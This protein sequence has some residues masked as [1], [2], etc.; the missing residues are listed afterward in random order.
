MKA[1]AKADADSGSYERAIQGARARRR[2]ERARCWPSSRNWNW[3]ICTGRPARRRKPSRPSSAS[4]RYNP[5]SPALDYALY[6]RALINFQRQPGPDG[7]ARRPG[8]RR[9][10]PARDARRTR[11]P[12]RSGGSC[13]APDAARSAYGLHRQHA[14]GPTRCTSR[15]TTSIGRCLRGGRQPRAAGGDRVPAG[16]G[17]GGS[18]CTSWCAATTSCSCCRCAIRLRALK[19]NFPDSPYVTGSVT[20]T[21]NRGGALLGAPASMHRH[22]RPASLAPALRRPAPHRRQRRQWWR[23][24]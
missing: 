21:A 8:H 5:S 10:R 24:P 23:R 11:L 16:T 7:H 9:A 13:Y 4:S 14:G 6:L 2:P 22:N 19:Q 12:Q 15:A 3:P 18:R 20:S 17:A 1:E